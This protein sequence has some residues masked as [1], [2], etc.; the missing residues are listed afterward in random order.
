MC[1][2]ILVRKFMDTLDLVYAIG[3]SIVPIQ[4]LL[5]LGMIY[6]LWRKL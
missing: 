5:L 3:H 6:F 2:L 4:I 1:D